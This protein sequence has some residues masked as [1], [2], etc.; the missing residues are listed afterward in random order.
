MNTHTVYIYLYFISIYYQ[1]T[2]LQISH[3][4]LAGVTDMALGEQVKTR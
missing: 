4:S 1:Y 3:M 2:S